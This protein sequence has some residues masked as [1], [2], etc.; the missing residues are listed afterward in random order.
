MVD[1]YNKHE[2]RNFYR[3][4]KQ[5]KRGYRTKGISVEDKEGKFI[6]IK[7]NRNRR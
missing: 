2:V 1:N 6:V 3:N 5:T 7:K 4:I